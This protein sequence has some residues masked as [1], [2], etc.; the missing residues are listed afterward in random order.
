MSAIFVSYRRI[1]ADSHARALFERL[2]REFGSKT[3][4]IDVEGI[5]PGV[6]FVEVL[7]RQL[8]P[9]QDNSGVGPTLGV[10]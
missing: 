3:V 10:R 9:V 1:G 7:N 2:S 8:T 5:E 4:F 6:D